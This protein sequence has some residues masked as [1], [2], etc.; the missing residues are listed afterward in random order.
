MQRAAEAAEVASQ[1]MEA[2]AKEMEKAAVVMSGDLP[3]T[4]LEMEKASKEFEILGR[5]LNRWVVA[6]CV[7]PGAAH[8]APISDLVC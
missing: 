4:L 6:V 7:R 8:Q 2:A 5:Q 3:V 1:Q